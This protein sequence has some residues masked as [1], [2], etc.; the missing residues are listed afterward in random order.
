MLTKLAVKFKVIQMAFKDKI[1]NDETGSLNDMTWV[2]GSA[3]VI[4][5]IVV[6]LVAFAPDQVEGF[7]EDFEDYAQDQFGF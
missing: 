2:V 6:A 1:I 4:V 5:A 3:V 7:W